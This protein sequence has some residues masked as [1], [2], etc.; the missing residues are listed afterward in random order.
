M[1]KLGLMFS[2][3]VVLSVA[4][5]AAPNIH[6]DKPIY[7]FGSVAEGIA[8]AH[9]FVIRNM[10]DETLVITR[11]AV[12]CGCTAAD[13]ATN[14]IAP[15]ESV[16]LK[17]VVDTA[18]FGGRKIS[19]RINVFSNDPDNPTLVLRI[20]GQVI[21]TAPHH[22]PVSDAK[23]LFYL[24][25]DV[26]TAEE[27]DAHHFLGAVN[28]QPE[29][30]MEVLADLPRDTFI[31]LYDEAFT[32]ADQA[33]LTLRENGFFFAHALVGGLNEWIHQYGMRFIANPDEHYELPQRVIHT[34]EDAKPAHHLL[35]G[36]LEWL[37]FLYVDVRSAAEHA[38]GH[39]VGSIN[40][41][42]PELE[43]RIDT[44]PQGVTLIVYDEMG[45]LGDRAAL[46]MINNGLRRTRSMLGGLDEW[47]RR[48]GDHHLFTVSP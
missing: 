12:S 41:P 6:V 44:L 30:L 15:G 25:V 24:L 9:T 21:R 36:E 35:A 1:K 33:A 7:D 26:R 34:Y 29:E 22:I 10:G 32:V 17:V 23:Y 39:I 8:I 20:T 19:Q 43:A 45:T 13:S 16:D 40:I 11:V 27:F 31:I 47:V 42:F 46:W 4:A 2:L 18:G 37:F 5:V 48:F 38:A 14:S 28:I 3:L